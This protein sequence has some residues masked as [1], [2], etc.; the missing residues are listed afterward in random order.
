MSNELHYITNNQK[1]VLEHLK[2]NNKSIYVAE[3]N[4][5][6]I[7]TAADYLKAI[8]KAFKFPNL[9]SANYKLNFDGYLDWIRDLSWLKADGYALIINHFADF[10]KN[11]I[12]N[13]KEIIEDFKQIIF[14][15]WDGEVEHC[16]V[17]GKAK[18]FNVYLLE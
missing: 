7:N 5:T 12:K 4:G 16:M 15:W 8:D 10:M 6:D 9:T 18:P 11:D 1:E 14:P 17:G 2:Q 3:L 13:K